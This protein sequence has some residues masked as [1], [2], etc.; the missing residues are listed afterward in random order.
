MN[1]LFPAFLLAAAAIA[2]PILLHFRR[3]PPQKAVAF[4]SLMFLEQTPVP[5]RTRRRLEDWLLLLLRCLA[6][7]LLA[8]MFARPFFKSD[9]PTAAA[10]GTR[11][12]LLV[13][14]SASMQRP[15]AW[16]NA[17]KLFRDAV[18]N[19]AEEDSAMLVAFDRIPRVVLSTETW[20]STTPGARLAL[21]KGAWPDLKP[22]WG[23]TD[24]GKALLFAAQ[25]LSGNGDTGTSTTSNSTTTTAPTAKA[26]ILLISDLQEG[27]SL[28]ALHAGSW[29][30]GITVTPALV[31]APWQENFSL[32]AAA[33]LAAEDMA[34]V[35]QTG[36]G[37]AAGPAAS[38]LRVRITSS[39]DAKQEKFSL[40]WKEGGDRVD[41]TIPPG[42]NRI[43][44]A[45][46]R[47]NA[48]TDGLLELRGDV[49]DFDN[50]LHTA[51]PHPRKV[52]VLCLGDGLTR[53]ETASPLFYLARALSPTAA[54]QPEITAKPVAQLQASDLATVQI[55]FTFGN[56]GPAQSRLL[57]HW[58]SQ[59]NALVYVPQVN[60]NAAV[61]SELLTTPG[62]AMQE[63]SGD[64]LLQDLRF[65]HP[66]LRAFAESGVR[67]FSR[68]RF[69][70]HR[71]LAPLE[72]ITKQATVLARF[73]D[74]SPAWIDLPI[75]MG[76][77][78]CM[79][80]GWSPA[81]SQLA[82][83]SKF[84]PLIFGILDW[85][86]G[87]A[88]SQRGGIIG[89]P[90]PASLG[91]WRGPTSL[92]RPGGH[93]LT[94]DTTAQPA[95]TNTDLPGIYRIGTGAEAR[96]VAINL[97]PGEGRLAPMD[98]Q[99]LTEVGVK[100]EKSRTAAE[101]ASDSV[102]QLRLEDSQHEQRQKGWKTLLLSALVILLLETWLAGRR[103]SRGRAQPQSVPEP[104]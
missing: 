56:A 9:T 10:T 6:L 27:A 22:T 89:D 95:Y 63:A 44:P 60:D 48:D 28:E 38:L 73:D 40:M 96:S 29:P 4:S 12:C 17:E 35:P 90:I 32:S 86:L 16:K 85:A 94:W 18:A 36:S 77:L 91:N 47:L 14:T 41:A 19:L 66:M 23:S 78:L 103:E 62:L 58:V 39:R 13:D 5:P 33:S 8:L 42:G 87:D 26:R 70:K 84:V 45:P 49:L 31:T 46:P 83:S 50:R 97:A 75:G 81:D 99:R 25:Q 54:L 52:H 21:L 37:A 98:E 101:A 74:G 92:V 43:L 53:T 72:A 1:F 71:T 51:R 68:I 76:R 55:V 3:Q 82:V 15:E 102:A 57:R 20:R 69:W 11:W 104:A 93:S 7:L 24:L 79:A 59:G 67:D 88:S 61:L 2:I 34:E 100:L 64:A 80:S 30:E 65:E